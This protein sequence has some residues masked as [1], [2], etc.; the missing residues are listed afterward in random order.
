MPIELRRLTVF[1]KCPTEDPGRTHFYAQVLDRADL[2]MP[3]ATCPHRHRT[4]R[5][6][7]RCGKKLLKLARD[8]ELRTLEENHEFS[9]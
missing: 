2:Q 9:P 5:A 3:V 6:A 8:E 4:H 1:I 7:L